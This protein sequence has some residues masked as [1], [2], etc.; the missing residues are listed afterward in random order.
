MI[1]NSNVATENVLHLARN[2]TTMMIVSISPMNEIVVFTYNEFLNDRGVFF[3]IFS[4]I[5][6][7]ITKKLFGLRQF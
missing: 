7:Y 2:V 6:R 1:R 5:S 4:K 3:N